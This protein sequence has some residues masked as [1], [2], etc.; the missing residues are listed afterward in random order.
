MSS[1]LG[2]SKAACCNLLEILL[3]SEI[4]HTFP[5]HKYDHCCL[6]IG[7][8]E[9]VKILFFLLGCGIGLTVPGLG[10]TREEGLSSMP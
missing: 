2:L 6:T 9:L 5:L 7:V 1:L 4:T 10:L 3:T 8:D